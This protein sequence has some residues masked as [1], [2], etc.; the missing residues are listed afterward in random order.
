MSISVTREKTNC[1]ITSIQAFGYGWSTHKR[2][3]NIEGILRDLRSGSR[4]TLLREEDN[5]YDDLAIMVLDEQ[6]RQLGYV[7]R[8][9]NP[10]LSAL[11]D[12]GK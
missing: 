3:L 12:A 7:P 6:G 1:G 2:R 9:S 4:V 10:V 5:P 11:M 8:K